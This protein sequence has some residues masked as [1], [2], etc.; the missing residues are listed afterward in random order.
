MRYVPSRYNRLN[1][2][3]LIAGNK[4]Q[5]KSKHIVAAI[6]KRQSQMLALSHQLAA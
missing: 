1:A 2:R 5:H 4:V 3:E 6:M